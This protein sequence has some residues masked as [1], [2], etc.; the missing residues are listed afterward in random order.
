MAK[1]LQLGGG[2]LRLPHTGQFGEARVAKATSRPNKGGP[3]T[4]KG[5]TIF[6]LFIFILF[7]FFWDLAI[8]GGLA[9]P[10]G[11]GVASATPDRESTP[12]TIWGGPATPTTPLF[13]YYFIIYFLNIK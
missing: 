11:H 4:P 13:F 2:W 7:L 10:K 3:A 9:T 8:G 6:Y 12:P 1:P 5:Q